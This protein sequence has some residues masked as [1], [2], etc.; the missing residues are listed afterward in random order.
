MLMDAI[1]S[2]GYWLSG[3]GICVP[4]ATPSCAPVG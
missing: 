1:S 2:A 3:E 4:P